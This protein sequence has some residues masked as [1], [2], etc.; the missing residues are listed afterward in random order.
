MV[1]GCS[2][3]DHKPA[4]G[5]FGTAGLCQQGWGTPERWGTCSWGFLENPSL[6]Q[7][8]NC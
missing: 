1:L 3:W 8:G 5:N 4:G 6:V 7:Q 2:G